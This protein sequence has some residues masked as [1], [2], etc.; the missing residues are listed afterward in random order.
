MGSGWSGWSGWKGWLGWVCLMLD[1]I[2]TSYKSA[3]C[4]SHC[5]FVPAGVAISAGV[6]GL[7]ALLAASDDV[8]RK[9]QH[10]PLRFLC[11]IGL[12][13]AGWWYANTDLR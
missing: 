1:R 6:R 3:Y 13:C 11:V 10:Q 2:G 9:H 4:V 7:L 8:H 5:H 12:S